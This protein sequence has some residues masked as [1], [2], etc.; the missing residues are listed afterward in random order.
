M[1]G[2]EEV[3]GKIFSLILPSS[4]VT[5]S[6]CLRTPETTSYSPSC[7]SS[8]SLLPLYNLQFTC[9]PLSIMY[10]RSRYRVVYCPGV[11]RKTL[12]PATP[13]SR[14]FLSSHFVDTIL[15][16]LDLAHVVVLSW[17]AVLID[18]AGLQLSHN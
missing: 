5:V 1:D 15:C 14:Q 6:L 17:C 18:V 13:I 9:I 12:S 11:P 4:S 10:G 2:C 7:S 16:V 3:L 8:P